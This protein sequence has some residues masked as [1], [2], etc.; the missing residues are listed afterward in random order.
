MTTTLTAAGISFNDGSYF[1]TVTPN[2]N[3]VNGV[4]YCC[5]TFTAPATTGATGYATSYYGTF[6][7]TSGSNVYI[8]NNAI[9]TVPTKVRNTGGL[10]CPVAAN[11]TGS[12]RSLTYA[13][14]NGYWTGSVAAGLWQFITMYRYA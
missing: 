3:A 5:L 7:T 1:D 12:W 11:A 10:T 4:V 2:P 13:T 6:Y 14:V 9:S 8:Y